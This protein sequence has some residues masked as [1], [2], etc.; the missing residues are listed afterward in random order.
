MAGSPKKE[1]P[2][3]KYPEIGRMAGLG[4]PKKQIAYILGMSLECF[5]RRIEEKPEIK[6]WIESGVAQAHLKITETAFA[7]A[8]SG[9][10]TSMTIFYLKTRLGWKDTTHV[11]MT[12]NINLEQLV[13]GS[14]GKPA[15]DSKPVISVFA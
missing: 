5:E 1:I 8:A 9:E 11:E 15:Q 13:L 12:G 3:S 2:E 10:N 6:D 7:M 14:I 4:L